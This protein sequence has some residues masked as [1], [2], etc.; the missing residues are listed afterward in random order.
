MTI[1]TLLE[2]RSL[3]LTKKINNR[4]SDLLGPGV[5]ED[6]GDVI[7]VPAQLKV[8]LIAPWKLVTKDGMVVEETSDNTRLDTPAGQT[9]VITVKAVYVDNSDPIVEVLAIELSAFN[10]L[11]DIDDHIVF[12]YVVVPIAATSV[13]SANIQNSA[14]Q[15]VDKLG[16][17]N[18]RGVITTTASLPP[19]EDN[20]DGD[21]YVVAAGSGAIPH[22][23]G[24]DGTGWLLLT[25]AAAVTADLLTHR[26]NLFPDEKHATDLEKLA[27]A[28][29]SGIPSGTNPYVTSD[30]P[31]VP[32]QNE[33][34]A[35]VGSDGTPSSA[36]LYITQ[37]FVWA[38]PEEKEIGSAPV[39][40]SVE[41]LS[42][43]GPV[44]VGQQ[45]VGSSSQY[46]KFY[47]S[48]E[49]REYTTDTGVK[50]LVDGVF[51]DSL[52]TSPLNPSIDP[53]VDAKGFY[54]TNSLFVKYDVTP[55]TG[56]RLS[57]GLRK[58]MKLFPVDA[59]L[60]RSPNDP[61]TSA[62][63]I[64]TVEAIK[65]RDWDVTPPVNEQNI[66][67]RKDIVDTREYLNSVFKGDY[68]A[69]DFDK[70][71]GVPDFN[72]DFI[73]NIGIPPN[74]TFENT[75]LVPII[76]YNN[77]GGALPHGV[78]TFGAVIPN[79]SVVVGNVF[80]DG[81]LDEYTIYEIASN[82]TF[83]ITR[84][85][86][87]VPHSINTTV[88]T[89]AHGS[90][91]PDNNPRKINLSTFEY[92]VGRERINT[93]EIESVGNE[94]HP[95]TGNV[96][97]QIKTPL[98]S[99][100]F[101]E[102]RVRFYGGFQNSESA[103]RKQ[104][105]CDRS[106]LILITGFF[107]DLD[108]LLDAK[109]TYTQLKVR[110]DGGT[111]TT[112][113]VG[114]SQTIDI[115]DIGSDLDIQQRR[116][117]LVTGLDDLV[118]HTV[119]I[120]VVMSN[121]SSSDLVIYG[122]DLFRSDTSTT[123]ILPGR[124][125]VQSELVKSDAIVTVATPT[126]TTRSRGAVVTRFI[127]RSTMLQQTQTDELTDFDGVGGPS[128]I[129]VATATS[130][131][132]TGGLFK[133]QNY[134]ADDIVKVVTAT[135]EEVM[136][137]TG[138]G[139]GGV[140]SF[141]SPL[142]NSG[143]AILVHVCSTN[144][145]TGDPSREYIRY[146]IQ[147]LGVEQEGVDF[148]K[149]F[150]IPGDRLYTVEDGTT[151]IFATN[152]R[153][154]TTNIAGVSVALELIDNTST[155]RI[156]AVCSGFDLMTADYLAASSFVRIQIDGSPVFIK[157]RD[158]DGLAVLPIF[159]NARYQTHEVYITNAQDLNVVGIILHEPASEVEGTKLA[160]QNLIADH[161]SSFE[162][163]GN[164]IPTG[165]IG[166]DSFTMGSIFSEG[167]GTGTG[168]S[169]T[170]DSI[171]NPFWGRYVSN[172]QEGG[173]FEKFFLGSGF[174]LEYLARDDFGRPQVFLNGV[175][176]TAVNFPTATIKGIITAGAN[177]GK[178]DMYEASATSLRKKFS[179]EG[180]T[181]GRFILHVIHQAPRDKNAASSD[182]AFNVGT[183]YEISDSGRLSYTA[184]RGYRGTT[185]IDDFVFG[186]D[187]AR[188]E[189]NFDSG[190]LVLIPA[191]ESEIAY[192]AGV[193]PWLEEP[194]SANLITA[195]TDETGSGPLVFATTPTLTTPILGTP[196]SGDLTNC[197]LPVGSLTGTL[198]VA[199]G[200]TGVT[201][202]TGTGN[203]VLSTSPTLTT[204]TVA[205]PA[206]TG[207]P[208]GTITSGVFT[209]TEDLG[210]RQN[211]SDTNIFP[212]RYLRVGDVITVS[213]LVAIDATVANTPTRI[214]LTLPVTNGNATT[215]SGVG[216]STQNSGNHL[217]ITELG[218]P[219]WLTHAAFLM[220]VT[221]TDNHFYYYT[222]TY[223]LT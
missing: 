214:L 29:T 124:A 160:T 16:R 125:F 173:L 99:I 101:K 56:F 180:L 21:L 128:G 59:L 197:T 81:N 73:N 218:A 179:V 22:I 220:F 215:I 205:T 72:N 40:T 35:L 64:V 150:F 193:V 61:Q 161:D 110:I 20:L 183:F 103:N 164:V 116:V 188:D 92:I 156:R 118:P 194:S 26:L 93:R 8:D 171:T 175:L 66:E 18:L 144:G 70:V 203:T 117:S 4:Y 9:S 76:S 222:Y 41:I 6:T 86:G 145:E 2:F 27:L 191:E 211:V 130:I 146:N 36:N 135:T 216:V 95:A 178:I 84:R 34:D 167:T 24:W 109:D 23:Y 127:N 33:N 14:R 57:Y 45:G 55:D 177:A 69:F 137:V 87:T 25:D 74:Y 187:W 38:V 153:Y 155:L 44:F 32:T 151:S 37:E 49:T 63:A 152:V 196:T 13:L 139:G 75:G 90:V 65:G 52:L 104:I 47:D 115:A 223:N 39:S 108:I 138:I 176:V 195:I 54:T 80:I 166:I 129:A 82:T 83:H 198:P 189:R 28:G 11:A 112:I 133:L 200:G 10:L 53:N 62:D 113:S 107:T 172:N 119:Q 207:I 71:D 174:E 204:P 31:R 17:R 199:S 158:D 206:F 131:A 213:G 170:K 154:V 122:F 79:G 19:A 60:K 46:F 106:G 91:K 140:V 111:Q 51:T 30:D 147:D 141:D 1:R 210:L 100:F 102:P 209:S 78:V 98:R 132:I 184:D 43:E 105:F 219:S 50:V 169:E 58:E 181:Y 42:S 168:W 136:V 182:T 15:T 202:S 7:I 121:S 123:A 143:A 163:D 149:L 120:E 159:S 89:S 217:G 12:A 77:F 5:F 94:Y 142:V 165:C 97:F 190:A 148:T 162:V 85:N 212:S 88:T 201:T 126:V 221:N 208:T 186:M 67:L 48:T 185:G 134:Q 96:A 3:D 68:V 192:A 114:D 157:E